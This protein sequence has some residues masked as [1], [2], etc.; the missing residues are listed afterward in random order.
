[1]VADNQAAAKAVNPAVASRVVAGKATKRILV[2]V[3]DPKGVVAVPAVLIANRGAK[4]RTAKAS[5]RLAFV[6]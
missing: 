3:A 5:L 6:V 1:V 4:I 2:A